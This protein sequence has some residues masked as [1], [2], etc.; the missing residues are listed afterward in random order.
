MIFSLAFYRRLSYCIC[1]PAFTQCYSYF[2]DS[3]ANLWLCIGAFATIISIIFL[4]QTPFG[5]YFKAKGFLH[6]LTN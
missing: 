4:T 5:Q 6:R 2:S 3:L 1:E